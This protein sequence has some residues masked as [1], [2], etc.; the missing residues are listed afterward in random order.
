MSS[1]EGALVYD[2]NSDH[3]HHHQFQHQ[4]HQQFTV[5]PYAYVQASPQPIF[6]FPPTSSPQYTQQNVKRQRNADEL[7]SDQQ[8][9]NQ[10]QV[11]PKPCVIILIPRI[12]PLYI[13]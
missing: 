1:L 9:P 2:T 3:Y 5:D 6:N 12:Y 8:H 10:Q 4:Q 7:D 11:K 13:S